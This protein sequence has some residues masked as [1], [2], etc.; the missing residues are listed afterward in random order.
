[1]TATPDRA[2]SLFP[3]SGEGARTTPVVLFEGDGTTG[4]TRGPSAP[5]TTTVSPCAAEGPRTPPRVLGLD[6]SISA[7]GIATWEGNLS[8]VGGLAADGDGRLLHIA[9]AIHREA[10]RAD[11][12]VI[13]DLPTHAH[14]AGVTG[15]VHGVV[16]ATLLNINVPYVL[17]PPAVLKKYATGRGNATKSDLR[18][19]LFQ[20]A[21]LDLRD[22]NQVDAWWLRCM[23][24][25]H[26]GQAPVKLPVGQRAALDKITWPEVRP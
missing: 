5:S 2:P 16:R 9:E 25:D 6:L 4:Q 19:V 20:R 26:L 10:A 12:A 1:M 21:G 24:L 18:M 8:T 22:D 15:M 14:G 23:G 7:T 11:W 17:V 13:E 3:G